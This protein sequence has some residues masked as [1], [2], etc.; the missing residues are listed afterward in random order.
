MLP[1]MGSVGKM[2]Q[3]DSDLQRR[4]ARKVAIVKF[5]E[6][7]AANIDVNFDPIMDV[8]SNP[9]NPV[10]GDRAISG[11]VSVV[12]DLGGEM[13]AAGQQQA[14][15][16]VAKHFPG[17][18]D[19]Y[20][21]SHLELPQV[22]K[23]LAQLWALELKPFKAAVEANVSGIMT[24][25]ILFPKVDAG[26]P[27]TMSRMFISNILRNAMHYDG[28][29]FSDSLDMKAV[30][31]ARMSLRNVIIDSVNAGVDMLVTSNKRTDNFEDRAIPVLVNAVQ[32]G[33]IPLWR[34]REAHRRIDTLFAAYVRQP[35][36]AAPTAH[37]NSA[38]HWFPEALLERQREAEARAQST[39]Q[40]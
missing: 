23:T 18:G 21:D 11:A 3:N 35:T 2:F 25:H 32:A 33:D 36:P 29:V 26:R 15:G 40:H 37:P 19:T 16:A 8:N 30:M 5:Q 38:V 13:I 1:R 9:S 22:Q 14:V 24:A 39:P 17:H 4:V 20:T 27:A 31:N 6:L 34:V 12:C 7:R 28:V 10:I